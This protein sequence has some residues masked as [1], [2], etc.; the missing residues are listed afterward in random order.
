MRTDL[1]A[2][3]PQKRCT[4]LRPSGR[5]VTKSRSMN[6]CTAR[7]NVVGVNGPVRQHQSERGGGGG[8]PR[9]TSSLC[10]PLVNEIPSVFDRAVC[11]NDGSTISGQRL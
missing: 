2:Q 11:D 5:R 1:N 4:I 6:P 10:H 3:R 7:P 9:A 8:I